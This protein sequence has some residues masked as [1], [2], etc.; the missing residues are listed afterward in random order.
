MIFSRFKNHVLTPIN[1]RVKTKWVIW[2]VK[3]SWTAKGIFICILDRDA[4]K[5]FNHFVSLMIYIFYFRMNSEN[6]ETF[7]GLFVCM[8]LL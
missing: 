6:L 5:Y 2:I 1:L 3:I 7:V 4:W 8:E